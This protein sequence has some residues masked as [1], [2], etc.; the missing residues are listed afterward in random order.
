MLGHVS[1]VYNDAYNGIQQKIAETGT[2]VSEQTELTLKKG[3]EV[4]AFLADMGVKAQ[5]TQALWE[6]FFAAVQ[7]NAEATISPESALQKFL[8]IVDTGTTKPTE[9]W[10]IFKT[11]VGQEFA[12][13]N[14]ELFAKM[15]ADG[16]AIPTSNWD[17]FVKK[18]G[19]TEPDIDTSS[20]A[21]ESSLNLVNNKIKEMDTNWQKFV[22]DVAKDIN[23]GEI[24]TNKS[25]EGKTVEDPVKVAQD[26]V[27]NQKNDIKTPPTTNTNTNTNNTNSKTNSNTTVITPLKLQE[28]TYED[29]L[30]LWKENYKTLKSTKDGE[31]A[32]LH[33][34]LS[35][36][37]NKIKSIVESTGTQLK[38][39][40]AK[41]AAK[42]EATHAVEKR[43]INKFGY[44]PGK[45]TLGAIGAELGI[46]NVDGK[47]LT[48]KSEVKNAATKDK[49]LN[50]LKAAGYARGTLGTA[51]D[52]LNWTH[53]GEIIRRSDG[54]ILRQLP[55]GTQVVPKIESENLLKW[56]Q[57]NPLKMFADLDTPSV[58]QNQTS[59][60]ITLNVESIFHIDGNVDA[61]VMDR[62]EELGKALSENRNFQKNITNIVTK[63][64]V[65]EGRK[66]G[67]K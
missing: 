29:Q 11:A 35:T 67:Y 55:A 5:T 47:K 52:E 58:V 62:L 26:I 23:V 9:N 24:V 6:Q 27:N 12:T 56:A 16:T 43:I 38:T 8:Y 40:K 45:T 20:K 49:I 48:A 44:A 33:T 36:V 41:E 30:K 61:D 17:D 22:S 21:F 15:V 25:S 13:E 50:A 65:R 57:I 54:A 59:Q 46:E 1:A 39:D 37:K 19:N 7:N 2:V 34:G 14:F 31:A 28:P 51:T 64:F 32:M 60:A 3:G 4:N 63:D 42:K 10:D 18:L 66:F 53:Q